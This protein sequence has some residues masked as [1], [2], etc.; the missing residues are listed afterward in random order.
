MTVIEVQVGISVNPPT[1]FDCTSGFWS[2]KIEYTLG[3]TCNECT[4]DYYDDSVSPHILPCKDI[5]LK[6]A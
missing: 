4:A 1:C 6:K 2:D 3:A 5:R